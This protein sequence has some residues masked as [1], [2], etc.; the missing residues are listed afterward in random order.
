MKEV[1]KDKATKWTEKYLLDLSGMTIIIT[2]ANS[3]TGFT[4][5][6]YMSAKGATIIMACRNPGKAKKALENIKDEN[7]GAKLDFIRLDLGDLASVKEFADRFKE[8]YISLDILIN[9]AGVAQTPELR[10]KDNFEMQLGINHLGHFALTGYLVERL[11]STKNARVVT[12]GSMNGEQGKM[13]FDNLF[14]EGEYDAMQAY[15]QSKLATHLFAYELG[16]RFESAGL[17]IQ[18]LAVSPGF[19]RSN[20]LKDNAYTTRSFSFKLMFGFFEILLAMPPERG[21]LS[22]M[23]AATDRTLQNGDFV[24]PMKMVGMRGLPKLVTLTNEA[25]T[26][27]NAKKLWDISEGLTG[28][29][30]EF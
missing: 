13:N 20:I 24:S 17:G 4:A 22:M 8:K 23:R 15:N 19:I 12:V 18:S 14:F 5:T 26:D 3:G 7:P 16:K 21:A 6:K 27:D 30:Y 1:E 29:K 25:Y 11:T 10:T 2:G 9:N 28:V